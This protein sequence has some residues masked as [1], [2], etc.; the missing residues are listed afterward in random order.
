MEIRSELNYLRIAPR[1]VRLV[2]NVI[3][4]RRVPEAERALNFLTRRAAGPIAKLLAS[5][6]ANA[7]QN[8]QVSSPDE[9]VVSRITVD[10][11][12]TLKRSRPRAFGRAFP[13]RKRTSHVTLILEGRGPG[14]GRR[15]RKKDDI[16]LVKGEPAAAEGETR[17]PDR[18]ARET[19]AKFEALRAKPRVEKKP[20]AFVRRMF[21]RK[22]I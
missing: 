17:L 14:A 5:A 3:R 20:T 22:A 16:A 21:R 1:K 18:Q 10:G 2:A 6:V 8:F 9:L 11:G 7:K 13:I 19:P 4:G 12:P 15:R